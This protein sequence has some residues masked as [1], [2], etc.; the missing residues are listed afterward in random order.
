MAPQQHVVEKL[1][2]WTPRSLSKK[3]NVAEKVG[4]FHELVY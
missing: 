4:I 1:M 3:M 2:R